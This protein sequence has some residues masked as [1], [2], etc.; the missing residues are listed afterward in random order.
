MTPAEIK[1]VRE[2]FGLYA[3]LRAWMNEV[4]APRYLPKC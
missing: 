3:R 4:N 1:C 2:R